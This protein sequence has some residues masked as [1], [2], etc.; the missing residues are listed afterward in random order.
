M[1]FLRDRGD[2]N[3]LN[4]ARK[5]RNKFVKQGEILEILI[6]DYAFGGKGIGRISNEHG[7]FVI[8]VPNTLPGQ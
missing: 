8:F 7:E 3:R 6:Q 2:L 5:I 1:L 4:M